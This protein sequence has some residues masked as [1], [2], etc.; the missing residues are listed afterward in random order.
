MVQGEKKKL[1][2]RREDRGAR[3]RKIEGAIVDA[4]KRKRRKTREEENL[5][6]STS[7]VREAISNYFFLQNNYA[8][9]VHRTSSR[10]YRTI[11]VGRYRAELIDFS[12][13]DSLRELCFSAVCDD[14]FGFA[15]EKEE[16][17]W[18]EGTRYFLSIRVLRVEQFRHC[19]TIRQDQI[20]QLCDLCFV[21]TIFILLRRL[22]NLFTA[23]TQQ[24][25]FTRVIV[26]LIEV[27]QVAS[28]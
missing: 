17:I 16:E 2:R 13:R 24:S 14:H 9:S 15:L 5:P 8:S 11:T 22:L 18:N 3:E 26:F 27:E 19:D 4:E 6:R 12:F 7:A 25:I 20:L 28:R 10:S 23:P 21:I 1:N